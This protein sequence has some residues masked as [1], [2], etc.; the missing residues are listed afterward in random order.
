[1]S[2][3]NYETSVVIN[4]IKMDGV[5]SANGSYGITESPLNVAGFGFTDAFLSEAPQGSFSFDRKMITKDPLIFDVNDAYNSESN[6]DGTFDERE[7]FSGAILYGEKGFGF[8]RARL[9]RYNISCGI[10]EIPNI[11]AEFTVLGQIS[12]DIIPY[13]DPSG[14]AAMQIPSQGSLKVSCTP[15][16]SSEIFESNYVSNFSYEKAINLE[17]I[18]A[19]P[20]GSD[21]MWENGDEINLSNT[22][23]IQVDVIDPIEIDLSFSIVINDH[24]TKDLRDR[25]VE[26]QANRIEIDIQDPETGETINKFVAP[27]ARLLSE[28]VSATTDGEVT[29]EL[30]FKSYLNKNWLG[31]AD[32]D[33][34]PVFLPSSSP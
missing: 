12:P 18:Y 2:Y 9:T 28:S 30:S 34:A 14:Q 24:E 29:A 27:Y 3:S 17:Q 26:T 6:P 31:T 32:A 19:L 33:R 16:G 10:D 22:F 20:T 11:H 13:F 7:Y 15:D 21:A 5:T 4:T 25:L 23:P 8:E 1:M